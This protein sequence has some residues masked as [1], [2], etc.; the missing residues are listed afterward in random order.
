MPDT[1]PQN[2]GPQEPPLRRDPADGLGGSTD[3][4][5]PVRDLGQRSPLS[6]LRPGYDHIDFAAAAFGAD[7]PLAPIDHGR[8]GAVAS[9]H[10]GGVGLNPMLA[11]L[12]PNDQLHAG[13]GSVAERYRGGKPS[14]AARARGPD[15]G[16]SSPRI[17][18][19]VRMRGE[20]G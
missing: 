14:A 19:S 15:S 2:T 7:Q 6:P 8:F 4:L 3:R 9:S 10:L 5:A 16:L 11:F 13:G 1:D 18:L 20:N 17:A 12:A